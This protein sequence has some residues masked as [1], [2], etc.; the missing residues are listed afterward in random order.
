MY[1]PQYFVQSTTKLSWLGTFGDIMKA[2]SATEIKAHLGEYLD[3]AMSQPIF[4]EKYG[5][6]RA[7]VIS[8]KRY[9]ELIAVEEKKTD[10]QP[11]S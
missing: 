8:Y 10:V 4:V 5:R 9:L 2:V 3:E 1:K 7:V 6:P 11:S